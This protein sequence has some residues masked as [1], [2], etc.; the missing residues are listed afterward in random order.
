MNVLVI[1]GKGKSCK[2]GHDASFNC[3]IKGSNKR[4]CTYIMVDT[5]EMTAGGIKVKMCGDLNV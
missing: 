4:F 1:D 5:L 3:K 2:R